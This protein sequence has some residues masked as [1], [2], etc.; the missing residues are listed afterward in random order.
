M[1][2]NGKEKANL[3]YVS[4]LKLELHSSSLEHQN[5]MFSHFWSL[6]LKPS[7]PF[8]SQAFNQ[9]PKVIS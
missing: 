4:F 5:S 9:E 6:G 3:L 2:Q 7:V 8:D 1:E